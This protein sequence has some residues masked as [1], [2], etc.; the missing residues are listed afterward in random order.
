MA[1]QTPVTP[2]TR[3]SLAEQAYEVIKR[4][5]LE[6]KLEPGELITE[7]KLAAMLGISKSPIR[8][9]LVHLQRDGLVVIT[10]FK[11]T[12]VAELRVEDVR[13]IYEAR[14]LIEPYVVEQVVPRLTEDDLAALDQILDR[15]RDSL[16]REDFPEFFLTNNEFHGFFI[17][18][19]SNKQLSS[20]MATIDSQMQRIRMIS[21]SIMSHPQKQMQEHEEIFSAVRRGDAASAA[22]RMR[23]HIMRYLDDVLAEVAS[24]RLRHWFTGWPGRPSSAKE[25]G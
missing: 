13:D 6:L 14:S 1:T 23:E 25:N 11:E 17:D 4:M 2:L 21:A 7:A 5:I 8:T 22:A 15:A 9:A 3:T 16:A 10:P 19:H 12:I 20:F 24:G 18:K